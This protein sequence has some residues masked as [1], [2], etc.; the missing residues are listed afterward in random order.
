MNWPWVSRRAYDEVLRQR[1][2]LEAREDQLLDQIVR[3]S[4]VDR[5]MAE[6]APVRKEPD[7][8]PEGVIDIING[9]ESPATRATL[10]AQ[11]RQQR[12]QGVKWEEIEEFLARGLE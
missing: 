9:F 7:P 11:C 6:V 1:D 5:G 8:F 3:M 2:R 12:A 4:R 10:V